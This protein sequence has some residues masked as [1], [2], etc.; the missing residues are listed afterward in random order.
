[1]FMEEHKAYATLFLKIKIKTIILE[2]CDLKKSM[3]GEALIIKI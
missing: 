1:M 3:A 2:I